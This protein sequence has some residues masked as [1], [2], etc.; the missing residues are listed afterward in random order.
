[1][2]NRFFGA[3][4]GCDVG[5]HV[6]F[7]VTVGLACSDRCCGELVVVADMWPAFLLDFDCSSIFVVQ[8]T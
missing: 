6:R 8:T 1:M 4:S 7:V 5:A 3:G 2:R